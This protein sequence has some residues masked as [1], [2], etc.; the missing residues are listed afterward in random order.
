V[1]RC[2]R[3]HKEQPDDQF[4]PTRR[5]NRSKRCKTC[6]EHVR[7][8]T[9]CKRCLKTFSLEEF[10]IGAQGKRITYCPRCADIRLHSQRHLLAR[11]RKGNQLLSAGGEKQCLRCRALKQLDD[12]RTET[13]VI[14]NRCTPCRAYMRKHR[15]GVRRSWSAEKQAFESSKSRES[16]KALRASVLAAYG[17]YCKCCGEST[18]EFLAIDHIEGDGARHRR[19]LRAKERPYGVKASGFYIWLRDT[20][21]PEGFQCLCHNCNVA[22]GIYGVCP[23]R[24]NPL[25]MVATSGLGPMILR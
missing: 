21:Y 6:L 15:E 9:T 3:C 13:G 20:G 5:G 17:G 22:K 10:R 19:S 4:E 7:Q 14:K 25:L 16:R 2:T 8:P 24:L 23:H 11:M 18:Q 12:F 1:M